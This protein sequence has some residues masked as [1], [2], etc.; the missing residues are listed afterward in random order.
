MLWWWSQKRTISC[1]SAQCGMVTY[2]ALEQSR[3]VPFIFF[4]TRLDG[5][6]QGQK[7]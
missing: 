4:T 6:L 2:A 5:D 7:A 3:I 1:S